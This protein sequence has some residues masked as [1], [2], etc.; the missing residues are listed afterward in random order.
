ML[1][2]LQQHADGHRQGIQCTP[3]FVRELLSLAHAAVLPQLLVPVKCDGA[4]LRR[5]TA[6]VDFFTLL[7]TLSTCT[8]YQP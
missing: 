6:H 5:I 3:F 1:C 8:C 4:Q 7:S 2:V